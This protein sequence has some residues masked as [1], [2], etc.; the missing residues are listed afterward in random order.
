MDTRFLRDYT[1]IVNNDAPWK[2]LSKNLSEAK[3]ALITTAGL[4]NWKLT[5][6]YNLGDDN[7][8]ASYREIKKDVTQQDIR[9]SH[10][11]IELKNGAG[12]DYN[13]IFPLDRLLEMEKEKR[14]SSV[15]E[16]HFSV[17][18]E[19]KDPKGFLDETVP[20]IIKTLQKFL[21]DVVIISA[22]GPLSHQTAGLLAREIEEAEISTIVIGS[23]RTVLKNVKPPRTVLVRFPFGQVFGAPFDTASQKEILT[24]CIIHI[25]SIKEPG[26]IAEFGFRWQ[27]SFKKALSAKPDLGTLITKTGGKEPETSEKNKIAADQF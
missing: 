11:V 8:D 17:M 22:V 4:Y 26:E 18:G 15:S 16:I 27:D 25:K 1:W 7:G 21:V 13:C 9:V 6:H 19:I 14:I 24:E 10:K 12:L 20:R 2:H 3:V 5:K 23:L